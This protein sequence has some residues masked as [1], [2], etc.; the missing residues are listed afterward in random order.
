MHKNDQPVVSDPLNM[1]PVMR[2]TAIKAIRTAAPNNEKYTTNA[3]LPKSA[4]RSS[5]ECVG[6]GTIPKRAISTAP[7]TMSSVPRIMNLENRSPRIK[8]AKSAFQRSDT[9]PRGAR[10]TTGREAIWKMEPRMLDEIK[11]PN[12]NSHNLPKMFQNV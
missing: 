2:L 5:K 10:M 9:A 4:N 3:S 11:I 6:S 12:P 8:R 7:A 1:D